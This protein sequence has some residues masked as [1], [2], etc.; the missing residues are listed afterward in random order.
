VVTGDVGVQAELLGN[1]RGRDTID[2]LAG[3]QVDA[4]PRRVTE[5]VGD[6]RHRRGE[7]T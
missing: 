5:C 3:E 6:C 7:R 4:A 1:L 2:V